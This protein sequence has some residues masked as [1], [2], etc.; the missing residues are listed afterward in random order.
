MVQT[1]AINYIPFES[2]SCVKGRFIIIVCASYNKSNEQMMYKCMMYS[3]NPIIILTIQGVL[4]FV[5]SLLQFVSNTRLN[6]VVQLGLQVLN[7]QR[8]C[9]AS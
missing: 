1:S 8:L 5:F 4:L 9:D 2:R 6:N 7:C 3:L